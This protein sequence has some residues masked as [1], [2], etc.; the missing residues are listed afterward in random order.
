MPTVHLAGLRLVVFDLDDTLYPERE[1]AY[2]GFEAAARWLRRR[3]TCRFDP[4]ARMREIFA[5]EDRR[6][7]F[8]RVLTELGCDD[9]AAWVPLLVSEYR[10]HRPRISLP[11]ESRR[12]L[13][14]LKGRVRLGLISDGPCQTQQNKADT[15]GISA[16]MDWI[17]LTDRWGPPYWKPHVRAFEE[18]ER[19]SGLAGSAC[20]YVGDNA[21]KDFVGPRARGWQSVLVRRA[22][23]VYEARQPPV[24]GEPDH[25]VAELSELQ[26]E[27]APGG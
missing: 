26:I 23:G 15:L 11:E 3:L 10:A 20:V 21:S 9:V 1:F 16:W 13:D 5:S 27:L 14:S 19:L 2:G 8:D 24:G 22:G 25:T 18:M 12:L 6:Q 17:V 7:V 4:A